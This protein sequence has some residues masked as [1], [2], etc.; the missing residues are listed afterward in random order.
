MI[1]F[2]GW[3]R[4]SWVPVCSLNLTSISHPVLK[5]WA[6]TQKVHEVTRRKQRRNA[7]RPWLGRWF[8]GQKP[9]STESKRIDHWKAFV[10][11][12]R[13][14]AEWRLRLRMKASVSSSDKVLKPRTQ[15][16]LH[17]LSIQLKEKNN[18][19]AFLEEDIQ[20]SKHQTKTLSVVSHQRSILKHSGTSSHCSESV[21]LFFKLSNKYCWEFRGKSVFT[22]C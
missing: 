7:F 9:H 15:E 16:E 6:T 4:E 17:N 19:N 10:L 1:A 13:Q 2:H 22:C 5:N 18:L 20:A 3:W 14:S 12:R 8:S 11:E 21:Y